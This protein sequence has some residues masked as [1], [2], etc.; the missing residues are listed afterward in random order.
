MTELVNKDD[1]ALI[2]KDDGDSNFP[3]RINFLQLLGTSQAVESNFSLPSLYLHLT[4]NGREIDVMVDTCAIHNVISKG[5][6]ARLGLS[7]GMHSSRLKAIN[8]QA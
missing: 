6:P 7:V 4:V 1:R 8:F 2:N 3:L 5:V